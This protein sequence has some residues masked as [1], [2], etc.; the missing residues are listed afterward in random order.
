MTRRLVRDWCTQLGMLVDRRTDVLL[1]VGEAAANVICRAGADELALDAWVRRG[2][3]IVSVWDCGDGSPV[4][5]DGPARELGR[6]IITRL[7]DSVDFEDPG[8]GTRVTMRF[9]RY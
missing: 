5:E 6:T 9:R 1:A 4:S 8:P 7:S 3:V 2:L